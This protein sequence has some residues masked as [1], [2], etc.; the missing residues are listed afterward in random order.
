MVPH[1]LKVK[2]KGNK[3]NF[4]L[5]PSDSPFKGKIVKEF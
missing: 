4:L 2:A 1:C 5:Q 3:H